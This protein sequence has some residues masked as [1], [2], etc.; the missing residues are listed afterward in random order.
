MHLSRFPRARL[1]AAVLAGVALTGNAGAVLAQ[2]STPRDWRRTDMS[3]DTLAATAVGAEVD[4]VRRVTVVILAPVDRHPEGAPAF[5]S[6]VFESEVRCGERLWQAM[7]T[8][9]YASDMSVTG[10][11]GPVPEAPLVRETPL[12]AAISDSC[13]DGYANAVGLTNSNPLEVVRWLEKASPSN[14]N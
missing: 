2:D 3:Q 11:R 1:A 5:R 7:K 13:D 8:T 14:T 4:G 6:I 12:H 10:S 9:Y